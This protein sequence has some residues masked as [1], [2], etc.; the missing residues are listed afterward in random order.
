M[1]RINPVPWKNTRCD[2]ILESSPNFFSSFAIVCLW[3]VL[4]ALC[5]P[6][7]ILHL[8]SRRTRKTRLINWFSKFFS[9]CLLVMTIDREQHPPKSFIHKATTFLSH[10][11]W[12]TWPAPGGHRLRAD[13]GFIEGKSTQ[14]LASVTLYTT[15]KIDD[16][17]LSPALSY[18]L[19]ATLPSKYP[20]C[21]CALRFSNPKIPNRCL[22]LQLF[23]GGA[24]H[25]NNIGIAADLP[26]LCIF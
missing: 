2:G 14:E 21:I 10:C 7:V 1:E 26:A 9:Y 11:R 3:S 22:Q 12:W 18:G 13:H 20:S 15:L 16:R 25:H 6:V 19:V 5:T 8:C 23:S 4:C 17:L 24:Y